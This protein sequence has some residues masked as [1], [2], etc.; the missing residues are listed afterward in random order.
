VKI[1]LGNFGNVTPGAV[2]GADTSAI[3]EAAAQ[4]GATAMRVGEQIHE[5]RIVEARGK[6]ANAILDHE[7]AVKSA[8][9]DISQ[10]VATGEID[11]DQARKTYDD[12]VAKIQPPRIDY[13]DDIGANALQRGMQRATFS[14]GEAVDRAAEVGRRRVMQAQFTDGLDKLGK[15]AGMPDANI[16]E[17]NTKADAFAPLARASGLPPDQVSKA[18]QDFKDRNWLNNAIQRADENRESI[19]GL[20]QLE[21]DLVDANGFYAGK[22]DTE[23]RNAVLASVLSRRDV[24]ENRLRVEGD[25]REA[26]AERTVAQIDRQIASGVPATPELWATWATAIK[27]TTF[28]P[29]FKQLVADEQHTQEILRRPIAEQLSYVQEQQQKLLQG[30]GSVRDAANVARLSEAVKQNVNLLQQAPLLFN[31]QRTGQDVAPLDITA[32]GEEGGGARVADQLRER[33]ITLNAMRKQYGD[34]VQIR[35]LLPQEV[36]VLAAAVNQASPRQ[37]SQ[38]FGELRKAVGDDQVFAAAVQQIAPDAPV[39]A[40]AGLLAAKQRSLTLERNWIRDDVIASSRDVSET[41]LAG[42]AILNR[43]K[44]DKT[45][46]GRSQAKL[47]LP[48]TKTLQAEFQDNVGGAF[49]GRPGAAELAFQA[50]QAYYVGKAAQTGRLAASGQDIDTKLVREAVRAT[51]GEVVDYNGHGEVLAP[52]GMNAGEF[53]A[54]ADAA[55]TSELKRRGLEKLT[56]GQIGMLGLRNIGESTYYVVQGRNFV[57]DPKGQPITITVAPAAKP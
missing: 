45:E 29:E 42:E 27:G 24:L 44:A 20:R 5:R 55:L 47:F 1:P 51:L 18:I 4:L 8:A 48:E 19:D 33:V 34:Q 25:K 50:V 30:G 28:E 49:A 57:F 53:R 16:D 35:P 39:K 12:T 36:Q 7:L 40:L 43:T 22:L 2:R 56:S 52:W 6:A 3:G 11:P 46:D 38:V 32:L 15:L 31:Q 23:R 9:D 13:L 10:K 54:S 17:I 37:T 14:A 41:M 26:R 21:H